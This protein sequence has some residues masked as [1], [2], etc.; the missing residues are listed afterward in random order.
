[1]HVDVLDADR[2]HLRDHDAAECVGDAS[3]DADEVELD[4]AVRQPGDLDAQI[5]SF[6]KTSNREKNG[7]FSQLEDR[8]GALSMSALDTR[9]FLNLWRSHEWSSSG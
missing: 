5:L 1:M 3:V 4:R 7:R 2:R 9:T 6:V 8:R